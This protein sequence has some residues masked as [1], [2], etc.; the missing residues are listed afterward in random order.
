MSTKNIKR[1]SELIQ[2]PT[3]EM[4]L[5]Y[6]KLGATVGTDTF[7]Y[8]RW[9][10]QKFYHLPEYLRLR[11]QIVIRDNGCDMG[12]DGYLLPDNFV[13]HHMN[14]ITADDIL[15]HSDFAWNPEYLICVSPAT[16]RAIH[17]ATDLPKPPAMASRSPNDTRPWKTRK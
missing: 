15:N 8:M 14:P 2:L 10:N 9:L 5:E 11:R 16:H 3:F 6:L 7:G 4:R 17:Y 12:T 13:L 1:Y